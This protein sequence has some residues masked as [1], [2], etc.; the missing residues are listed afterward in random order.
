M[1]DTIG[2]SPSNG[3]QEVCDVDTK[4]QRIEMLRVPPGT[5]RPARFRF[6]LI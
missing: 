5:E 1:F 3:F 6:P 2:S 4:E